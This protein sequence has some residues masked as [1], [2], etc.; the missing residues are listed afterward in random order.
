MAKLDFVKK[1]KLF[2]QIFTKLADNH[3]ELRPWPIHTGLMCPLVSE[4]PRY[5]VLL[6]LGISFLSDHVES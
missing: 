5:V 6:F 3:F 2:K 1:L 4:K